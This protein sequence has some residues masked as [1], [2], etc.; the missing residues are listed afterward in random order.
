MSK[1]KTLLKKENVAFLGYKIIRRVKYYV[2]AWYCRR[3][4]FNKVFDVVTLV[5]VYISIYM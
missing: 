5:Y 4:Y 3:A 1:K 2:L